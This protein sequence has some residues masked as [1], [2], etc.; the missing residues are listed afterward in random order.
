FGKSFRLSDGIS[1][2]T[3]EGR[4]A[5]GPEGSGERFTKSFYREPA[6]CWR[7]VTLSPLTLSPCRLLSLPQG[8]EGE[9]AEDE[10]DH[11]ETDSG[12]VEGRLNAA[13]G[14]EGVLAPTATAQEATQI[15]AFGLQQDEH[16]DD[17]T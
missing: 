14:A 11:K 5:C 13:P 9:Q 12:P 3:G 8:H 7:S 17:H 4:D 10:E 1:N 16:G 2:L 6:G 15:G